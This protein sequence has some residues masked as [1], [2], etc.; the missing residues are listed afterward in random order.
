MSRHIADDVHLSNKACRHCYVLPFGQRPQGGRA[1]TCECPK[2]RCWYQEQV[3][4]RKDGLLAIAPSAW[5]D[6]EDA[7]RDLIEAWW[8]EHVPNAGENPYGDEAARELARLIVSK[9][10]ERSAGK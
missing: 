3:T 8:R 2:G 7:I 6:D 1:G 10:A 5:P 4:R 9:R